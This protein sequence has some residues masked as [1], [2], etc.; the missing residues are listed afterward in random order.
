M[1]LSPFYVYPSRE[2]WL[3]HFRDGIGAS[4]A[5]AVLGVSPWKTKAL[6]VHS[7]WRRK[8]AK[9]KGRAPDLERPADH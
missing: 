7:K 3:E 1:T 8:Y 5:A 4:E 9:K 2:A 6:Q